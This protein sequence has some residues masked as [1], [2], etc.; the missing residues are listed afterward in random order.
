M[1][2]CQHFSEIYFYCCQ[3][4]TQAGRLKYDLV[5]NRAG[6]KWFVKTV[7]E[8]KDHSWRDATAELVL[9]VW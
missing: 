2:T 3:A 9:Q 6:N 1:V 4:R 7:M 5:S 8:E